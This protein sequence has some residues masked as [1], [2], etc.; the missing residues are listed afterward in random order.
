MTMPT[1]FGLALAKAALISVGSNTSPQ[2]RSIRVTFAPAR[3]ATSFMRPPNTPL[4]QTTIESPG[5]I[6]L[7]TVASMPADPVPLTANVIRLLV[8]QD[9]P[10]HLLH[11]VHQRQVVGIEMTD[12]R[13]GERR[14]Y[15]GMHVARSR[16]QQDTDRRIQLPN[17][18]ARW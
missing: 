7:T 3:P 4:T 5:S 18:I 14:Q 6:R 11:A 9:R 17:Q 13:L 15:P 8:P 2:G 10:Q 1:T 12:C 16:A